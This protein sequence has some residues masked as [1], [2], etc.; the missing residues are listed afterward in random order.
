MQF[1]IKNGKV[2]NFSTFKDIYEA[3]YEYYRKILN[4]VK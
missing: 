3:N 4:S 2:I 1:Q